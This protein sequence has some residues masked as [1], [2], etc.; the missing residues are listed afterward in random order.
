MKPQVHE[1][2]K[3]SIMSVR[4]TKITLVTVIATVLLTGAAISAKAQ[5]GFGYR[6]PAVVVAP[7]IVVVAP[8]ARIAPVAFYRP[9]IRER[10]IEPRFIPARRVMVCR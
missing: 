5:C 7:R 6:H 8:I 9:V 2:H 1:H 4:K 10:V 3:K